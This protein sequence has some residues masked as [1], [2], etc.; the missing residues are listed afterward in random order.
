MSAVPGAVTAPPAVGATAIATTAPAPMSN[1]NLNQ[2]V[3]DYLLKRGYTRTELVFRDES[4]HIGPDGRPIHDDSAIMGPKKYHRAFALLRD[5]VE[6]NLEIYKFELS[7]LLWPYF[8][9]AWIELLEQNYREDAKVLLAAVNPFFE[10]YHQDDLR[11]FSTITSPENVKE[12]QITQL[13]KNNKYKIPLNQAIVGPLFHFLERENDN[14]GAVI[15][16]VIQAYCQIESVSRGPIEPF[17]FEAIYRRSQ[18]LDLEDIDRDEG[19]SGH[20][21]GLSNKDVL[22]TTTPLKLGPL[23]MEEGLKDDV[24]AELEEEDQRN[25]PIAGKPS[26]VDEFERR[27]KREESSDVPSRNDIP[28][29]PSRA[30]DVVMEMQKVRENRDRFKM[31][32]NHTGGVGPGVSALMYTFHN[33]CGMVSCLEFSP[34]NKLAAAGTMDSYIRVWTLDGSPLTTRM[35]D[36]KDLKINNR[37]LI[38]HSAPV[39]GLSFSDGTAKWDSTP[40]GNEGKQAPAP[41]DTSTRLLLSCSADGQIRLWSLDTW[42]CLCVYR[43]HSGPV[44]RVKWSPQG[45]YF[46]SG[47][48]DRTARVWMQDHASA[49]R[50]LVGHDTSISAI[51]WHPNGM[52]VFSASDETDKTI[53]MWSVVTGECVRVFTGHTDYIAAIECSPNGKLIVSGD[54]AGNIFYWDLEKGTRIKRSRGHGKGGVTSLSFDSESLVLA[55]GGHDG[56]VR[57]WDVNMPAQGHKPVTQSQAITVNSGDA[58]TANGANASGT[59]ASGSNAN[60]QTGGATNGTSG[61]GGGGGGGSGATGATSGSG[62]RKGKEVT[63]TADQISALPT[64]QTPVLEV[65]FT[66]MNLVLAGGCYDPER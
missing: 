19:I 49:Q 41:L 24:R 7:K 23:P 63:I 37:K 16:Y 36:E 31:D 15:S 64:K 46:L 34:D 17:S 53:R 44:M 52:Y 33:T 11:V 38:G 21:T 40:F 14:G 18:G 57:I 43:G 8:V 58:T 54:N 66:R 1:Q 3:T 48:W 12:N 29:P 13:Y 39:F 62:K 25:P 20:Y 26:L 45:H 6:T 28:L 4:K 50:L 42:T 10:R 65:Q 51:T 5:W 61:S 27:I 2:I 9:Y 56:S 59:S 30:R 35:A 22:T 47:G 60:G 32:T 55:S